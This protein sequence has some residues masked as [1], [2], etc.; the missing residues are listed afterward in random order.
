MK[1]LLQAL[2]IIALILSLLVGVF[3]DSATG[4]LAIGVAIYFLLASKELS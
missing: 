3:F 2:S 4:L 1:G